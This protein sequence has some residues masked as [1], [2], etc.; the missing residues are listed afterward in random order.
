MA[1]FRAV[2]RGGRG[3]ASRLGHKST[4]ISTRLQTWGWDVEVSAIH[5]ESKN[6]DTALV[7]LV[8][9]STGQRIPLLDLCLDNYGNPWQPV[10]FVYQTVVDAIEA[11]G[12]L[13]V[14]PAKKRAGAA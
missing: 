3:E 10:T 11:S 9:H 8:N 12:V 13:K 14:V 1:H 6:S 2:I 4:G 7:E 5:N